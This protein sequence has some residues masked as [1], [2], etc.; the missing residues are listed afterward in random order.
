VNESKGCHSTRNAQDKVQTAAQR[1]KYDAAKLPC[2]SRHRLAD[3]SR[4]LGGSANILPIFL[5]G[6]YGYGSKTTGAR[7]GFQKPQ[8]GPGPRH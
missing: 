7:Q 8:S 1:G 5:P 4:V 2:S 3:G 6:S